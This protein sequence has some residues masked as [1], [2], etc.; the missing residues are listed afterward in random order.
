MGEWGSGGGHLCQR[1]LREEAL[2]YILDRMR[3]ADS[4]LVLSGLDKRTK[5]I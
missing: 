5:F 4:Y 2:V 3:P 1:L